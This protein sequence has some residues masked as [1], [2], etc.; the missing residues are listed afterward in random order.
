MSYGAHTHTRT[1]HKEVPSKMFHVY[2][3]PI[4]QLEHSCDC[5]VSNV[6]C[7]LRPPCT[8]NSPPSIVLLGF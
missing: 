8:N 1:H 4:L 6:M 5:S 7:L 2:S 3:W